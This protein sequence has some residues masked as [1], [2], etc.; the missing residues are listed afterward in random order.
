[1][2]T[3]GPAV[4]YTVFG[5]LEHKWLSVVVAYVLYQIKDKKVANKI[6]ISM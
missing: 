3:I 1:M 4:E 5:P 6:L 2:A